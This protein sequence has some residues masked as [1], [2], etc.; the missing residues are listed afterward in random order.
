M[1]WSW[2]FGD[3]GCGGKLRLYQKS[4]L[5]SDQPLIRHTRNFNLYNS[6]C[7]MIS[8]LLKFRKFFDVCNPRTAFRFTG[9]GNEVEILCLKLLQKYLE[10]TRGF[11]TFSAKILLDLSV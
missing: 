1:R 4:Y 10:F 6:A 3:R 11:S 5:R 2:S 7:E 8:L 9:F